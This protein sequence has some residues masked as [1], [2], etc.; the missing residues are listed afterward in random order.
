MV[1]AAKAVL[2]LCIPSEPLLVGKPEFP[3]STSPRWLLYSLCQEVTISAL[4][5]PPGLLL[6]TGIVPPANSGMVEV[7]PEIQG[8]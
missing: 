2:D 7:L 5:E 1:I 3:Q 6:S 8:L 4:Q